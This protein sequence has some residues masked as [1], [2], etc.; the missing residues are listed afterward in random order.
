MSTESPNKLLKFPNGIFGFP[1][2]YHVIFVD[3]ADDD[4][5]YWL[6]CADKPELRWPVVL[7]DGHFCIVTVPEDP[8][9]MTA[10]TKAPIIIHGDL[11]LGG[12]ILL[13]GAMHDEKQIR[14]PIFELFQNGKLKKNPH[15]GKQ[16]FVTKK[17]K[18][19]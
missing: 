2:L 17:E 13:T 1:D 12:Q 3:Y 8:V 10:N 15:I 16:P 18:S 4:L 6:E 11:M 7:I 5:F 14:K 9:H 19:E